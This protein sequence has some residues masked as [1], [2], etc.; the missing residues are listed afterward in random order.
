MDL[1]ETYPLQVV[2][3]DADDVNYNP[4]TVFTRVLAPDGSLTSPP[5]ANPSVGVFTS[6]VPLTQRGIIRGW[7]HGEGPGATKI[8]IPFQV[9]VTEAL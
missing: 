6:D 2:F 3:Q 4:T 5:M 7:V 8:I 9:C 1:G